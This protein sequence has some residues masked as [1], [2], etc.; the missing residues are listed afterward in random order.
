MSGSDFTPP[1]TKAETANDL[2][3]CPFCGSGDVEPMSLF[4]QQ[5]LTVQFYCRSC[6]TP[7]EK[8]KDDKTL[9]HF[10]ESRSTSL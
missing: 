4:G 5:L 6:K 3:C 7:F 1:E 9:K 10:G 8:V 2:P